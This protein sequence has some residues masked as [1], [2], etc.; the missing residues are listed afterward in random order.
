MAASLPVQPASGPRE[1]RIVSRSCGAMGARAAARGVGGAVVA[2][3]VDQ[4][5]VETAG[6]ILSEERGE[7]RFDHI[8]LVA[9]GDDGDDMGLRGRVRVQA[10]NSR[11]CSVSRQ[12]PPRSAI[13]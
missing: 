6:E 4:H 10:A 8:R 7:A 12:K 13:R 3:V 2:F 9:R 1:E 11:S 5:D